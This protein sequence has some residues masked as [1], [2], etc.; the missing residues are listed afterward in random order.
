M[1][2]LSYHINMAHGLRQ[3]F[4]LIKKVPIPSAETL[5]S[6]SNG[7]LQSVFFWGIGAGI[8]FV[9]LAEGVIGTIE[10][11]QRPPSRHRFDMEITPLRS[12]AGVGP[13]F[14]NIRLKALQVSF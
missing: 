10:I 6:C 14:L 4:T 8:F 5:L 1:N 2:D 13:S 9:K 3:G 12:H 7:D 11:D